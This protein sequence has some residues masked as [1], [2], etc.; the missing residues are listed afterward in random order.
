MK[1]FDRYVLLGC[2]SCYILGVLLLALAPVLGDMI[3][4]TKLQHGDGM[5]LDRSVA[6][7]EASATS[8]QYI[9]V[10]IFLTGMMLTAIWLFMRRPR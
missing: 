4:L 9:G 5:P 3:L 7:F 8:I 2:I 1:K 10:L 6:F